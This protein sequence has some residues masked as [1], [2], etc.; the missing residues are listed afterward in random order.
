MSCSICKYLVVNG[1]SAT[2]N[3][4]SKYMMECES[5]IECDYGGSYES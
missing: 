4:C 5:V 3:W 2:C 1:K